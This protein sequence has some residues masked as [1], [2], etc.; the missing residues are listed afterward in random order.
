LAFVSVRNDI[1][2][3]TLVCQLGTLQIRENDIAEKSRRTLAITVVKDAADHVVAKR[4]CGVGS[5]PD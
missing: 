4:G 2:H 1:R 5:G 3:I